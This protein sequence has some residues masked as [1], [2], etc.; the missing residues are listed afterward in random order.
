MFAA[1]VRIRMF[2]K[3]LR[4][5]HKLNYEFVAGG[6]IWWFR[7]VMDSQ[8]KWRIKFGLAPPSLPAC[9]KAS[10]RIEDDGEPGRKSLHLTDTKFVETVVPDVP[11][12]DMIYS[13]VAG[14][15]ANC[16]QWSLGDWV[17]HE[18]PVHVD[19]DGALHVTMEM[20]CKN[21]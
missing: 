10:F 16:L 17:M 9:P 14:K 13:G 11:Y 18:N 8:W 12:Y 2:Q 15:A 7:F 1:S 6:R 20:I 5:T 21:W 3:R 19:R 4:I